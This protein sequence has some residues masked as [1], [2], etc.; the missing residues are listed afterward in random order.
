[1][2]LFQFCILLTWTVNKRRQHFFQIFETPLPHVGTFLLLSVGSFWTIFEP[3]PPL[4]RRRPLWM[5]PCV[6]KKKTHIKKE[7]SCIFTFYFKTIMDKFEITMSKWSSRKNAN[8][9]GT[10]R[11]G[12]DVYT[13]VKI[14]GPIDSIVYSVYG[15]K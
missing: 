10:L 3:S 7:I 8:V 6:K 1:M 12:N 13:T 2:N 14:S 5:V 9:Y 11:N 4:H 15:V